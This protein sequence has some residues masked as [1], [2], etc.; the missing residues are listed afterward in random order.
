MLKHN[1]SACAFNLSHVFQD[2][3]CAYMYACAWKI[4]GACA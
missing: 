4:L 1:N 3:A 2:S